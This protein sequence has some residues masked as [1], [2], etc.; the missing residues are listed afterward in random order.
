MVLQRNTELN[1]W[2][3]G[4]ANRQI[5]VIGSWFQDTVKTRVDY[6]GKWAVKLPAGKAGGPYTLR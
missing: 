2:G 3:W 1:F 5:K 4:G 6:N